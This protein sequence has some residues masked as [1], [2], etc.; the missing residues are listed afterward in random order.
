MS[1][2]TAAPR[3]EALVR[4]PAASLVRT[5]PILAAGALAAG[6]SAIVVLQADVLLRPGW[7]ALFQAY[8]I[9]AFAAVGLLW[10]HRRPASRVGSLLLVLAGLLTVVSL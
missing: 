6:L 3:D 7:F 2:V 4:D 9:L 8:N 1:A 5:G 10:L